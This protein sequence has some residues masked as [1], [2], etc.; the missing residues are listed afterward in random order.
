MEEHD[1]IRQKLPS[2]EFDYIKI[3]KI[4]LS[5]WYWIALSV[6]VCMAAAEIY[7][8]FT[9][10][11]FATS[12]KMKFEEKKSDL[13]D[14][15][16]VMGNDKGASKIQSE[17]FVL[18]S[19]NLIV[20][21]VK[22]LNYDVSLYVEGNVRTREIYPNKDLDIK[23]L[24]LDSSNYYNQLITFKPVDA[25][26]FNLSYKLGETTVNTNYQYNRKVEIG[27]TSFSISY[28]GE[29]KKTVYLFKFN[30]PEEIAGRVQG[31]L[32][33]GEVAKNSNIIQLG[34][35]DSHPGFAAA[36][37]NAIMD[38]YL[39]YDR[40][41]KQQSATQIISFIDTQLNGISDS[42]QASENKIN[43]FKTSSQILDVAS[44]AQLEMNK[45]SA[46]ETQRN[47]LKAQLGAIQAF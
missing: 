38:Q 8:Y 29:I 15:V 46:I 21:A 27:N 41:H 14:L 2:Q 9:P 11:T 6:I 5:R 44:S 22:S 1:K 34:Q 43:S 10:Q 26:K 31:G 20:K 35:T 17:I 3:G 40:E 25:T 19:R 36:A 12:A 47:S 33:I 24:R 18:Q 42:V 37:L 39:I 32:S 16:S 7:L 30:T 45:A 4:L 28:P 23:I 13:S